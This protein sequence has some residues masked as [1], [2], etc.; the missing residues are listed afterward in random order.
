[1]D[2]S[3]LIA[4]LGLGAAVGL[5]A[6]LARRRTDRLELFRTLPAPPQDVVELV[7]QV[8]REP[9]LIPGVVAV[10]VLERTDDCVR[11]R[12]QLAGGAWVRY[13][14]TWDGDRIAWSSEAGT[15]G[16]D[17]TGI[18]QLTPVP[19]GTDV[20]L[21][22]E[23]SFDAPGIGRLAAAGSHPF[24]SYALSAWLDNLAR[25]LD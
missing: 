16:V 3:K 9:E 4:G 17:Q 5:L 23:T 18:L 11:Y 7:A 14:K 2:R 20:H 15:L 12:V 13:S 25:A 10:R 21:T 8:E 22:V 19:G 24:A 1:M 6:V